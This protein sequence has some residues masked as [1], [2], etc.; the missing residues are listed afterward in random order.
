VVHE[1]S[2][3]WYVEINPRTKI[4]RG[5]RFGIRIIR[6]GNYERLAQGEGYKEHVDAFRAA[7]MIADPA[8]ATVKEVVG[9]V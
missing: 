4:F 5:E 7:H 2:P 9:R 1:G 6:D 8:G 3:G